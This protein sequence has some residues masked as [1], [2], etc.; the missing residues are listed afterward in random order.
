MRADVLEWQIWQGVRYRLSNIPRLEQD[1]RKAQ[2]EEL[3]ALEPKR[4]EL[5]AI[6]ANIA[7]TERKA[8]G[9]ARTLAVLAETDPDGIVTQSMQADV[10]QTNALHRDQLKRRAELLDDLSSRTF[11]E[12]AIGDILQY[13]SDIDEGCTSKDD[14]TRRKLL[15]ILGVTVIIKGNHFYAKCLLGEWS[16]EILSLPACCDLSSRAGESQIS[17]T[18]LNWHISPDINLAAIRAPRELL[19][20]LRAAF[21][22]SK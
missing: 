7:Q 6:E 2:Q 4:D 14:A 3:A 18:F 20:P 1:L 19:A 5:E 10:D 9:L 11:T 12:E 8:A 13:A 17:Q 21:F 15:E 16:A 22:V